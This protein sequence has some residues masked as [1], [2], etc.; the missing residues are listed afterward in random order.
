M[1]LRNALIVDSGS[2]MTG[3]MGFICPIYLS[4]LITTMATTLASIAA[5]RTYYYNEA[6]NGKRHIRIKND[7]LCRV[8]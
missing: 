4:Y 1:A 7:L 5:L 6:E 3:T 2:Y 8:G